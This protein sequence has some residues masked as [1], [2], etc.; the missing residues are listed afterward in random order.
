MGETDQRATL[1]HT[2]REVP[3]SY[4]RAL[5]YG[6]EVIYTVR[7]SNGGFVGAGEGS[8]RIHRE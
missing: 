2:L 6:S 5:E 3:G 1:V 4:V 7:P 8:A